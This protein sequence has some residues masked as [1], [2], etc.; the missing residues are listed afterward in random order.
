MNELTCEWVYGRVCMCECATTQHPHKRPG[1]LG[2]TPQKRSHAHPRRQWR[3][4]PKLRMPRDKSPP[5]GN[6]QHRHRQST[7]PEPC[8]PR[9]HPP[10][11]RSQAGHPKGPTPCRTMWVQVGQPDITA[12]TPP[13]PHL[14]HFY[15]RDESAPGSFGTESSV[16]KL[17]G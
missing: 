3:R 4:A 2:R 5:A 12:P 13:H 14:R 11:D 17:L 10:P 16:I 8:M 15:Y 9:S 6:Q 1:N 7:G